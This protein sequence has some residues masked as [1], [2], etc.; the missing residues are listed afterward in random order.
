MAK[1]KIKLSTTITPVAN[2]SAGVS[3]TLSVMV[4]PV[5]EAPFDNSIAGMSPTCCFL[6]RRAGDDSAE[7]QGVCTVAQFLEYT[8][9]SS[10]TVYRS[11]EY[12]R[13]YTDYNTPVSDQKIL[14]EKITAFYNNINTYVT[15]YADTSQST[16]TFILP[17]YTEQ[18]LD[19]LISTWRTLKLRIS[20]RES[21]LEVKQSVWLPALM[22]I[23]VTTGEL[24]NAADKLKNY[25]I[26]DNIHAFIDAGDAG[27]GLDWLAKQ[28]DSLSRCKESNAGLVPL[29][30]TQIDFIRQKFNSYVSAV[31]PDNTS[32]DDVDVWK[33]AAADSVYSAIKDAW[34]T[35]QQSRDMEIPGLSELKQCVALI[36]PALDDMRLLS[37][38]NYS[39]LADIT[40]VKD[41]VKNMLNQIDV[42]IDQANNDIEELKGRIEADKSSLQAVEAQMK[43][44]RP[45]I[46]LT[47]PESAWYFTVNVR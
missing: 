35:N 30:T 36:K 15:S 34:L 29:L 10:Q 32:P 26:S 31:V 25:G 21:E 33:K 2:A 9:D 38:D 4:S 39:D 14:I 40:A 13:S 27:Y 46:D 23:R 22:A 24:R 37:Q 6:Y 41:A 18:R 12:K 16:K 42:K 28:L 20:A 5:Q 1:G 19:S 47:N 11:N 43:Q 8:A 44:I 7:Y 17:D 3:F 45:S